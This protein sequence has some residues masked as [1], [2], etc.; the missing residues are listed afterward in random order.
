M[1]CSDT[2]LVVISSICAPATFL[3]SHKL[4]VA[5]NRLWLEIRAT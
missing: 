1:N 5:S 3:S 2:L 4:T